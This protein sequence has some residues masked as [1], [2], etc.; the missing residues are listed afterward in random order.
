MSEQVSWAATL[1]D[2]TTV[3][4]NEGAYTIVPGERQPWVRFA[5]FLA[6]NDLQLTSLRL[7]YQGRTIHLPKEAFDRFSLGDMSLAPSFYSLQYFI[8][9]ELSDGGGLEQR[10]FID[11][12]AHYD[13]FE[14]HHIHDLVDGT[15]WTNVTRGFIPM[16]PTPNANLRRAQ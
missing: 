13:D 10:N 6:N 11:L 1:S 3:V 5:S 15:S 8:E 14:I 16:A 9:A 7:D 12:V 4:E 2:G